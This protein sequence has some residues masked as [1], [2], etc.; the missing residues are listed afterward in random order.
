MTKET[1]TLV[2]VKPTSDPETAFVSFT[3]CP[4]FHNAYKKSSL[5]RYNITPNQYRYGSVWYPQQE[6]ESKIN[7]TEIFHEVTY[8]LHEIIQNVEIGT[9][10]LTHPK[11]VINPAK[12]V[13][14]E[15]VVFATKYMDTFGRCYTMTPAR[16]LLALRLT[17]FEFV[18]RIAVYVYLDHPGQHLHDNSRAKVIYYIIYSFTY[19]QK[20]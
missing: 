9:M 19:T 8:E 5:E 20:Q 1:T 15:D 12:E 4:Q 18:T 10:S 14:R 16:S 2:R 3:I 13:D 11:I 6:M 17:K 7:G